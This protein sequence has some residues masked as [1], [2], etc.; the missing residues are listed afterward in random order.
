MDIETA[1][2]NA[3]LEEEVYIRILEGLYTAA[4]PNEGLRSDR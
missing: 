3:A 2:L 1:F 4:L